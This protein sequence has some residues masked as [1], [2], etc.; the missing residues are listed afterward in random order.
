MLQVE[1]TELSDP[2]YAANPTNRCYFCK[3]VLWDTLV[4]LA[5]ER[6][7]VTVID[8]TNADDLSDYRPGGTKVLVP[9]RADGLTISSPAR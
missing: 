9:G 6:G 7:F 5:R 1:T 8:G 4:P 3:S 2:R